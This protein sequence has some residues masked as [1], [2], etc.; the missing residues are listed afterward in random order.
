ML[1]ELENQIRE[2]KQKALER[3]K[4]ELRD[5]QAVQ[6]L[7]ADA[8]KNSG[9]KLADEKPK[10]GPGKRA[11][12]QVIE[13]TLGGDGNDEMDLDDGG[14]GKSRM[15]KRGGGNGGMKKVFKF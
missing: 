7:V 5:E 13:S 2:V 1:D 10:A 15:A 12:G 8:K 9:F 3:R 11:A 4:R 6:G 14:P